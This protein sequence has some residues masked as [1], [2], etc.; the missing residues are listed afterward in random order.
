MTG[1][2]VTV[3]DGGTPI[4]VFDMEAGLPFEW[5]LETMPVEAQLADGTLMKSVAVP[6]YSFEWG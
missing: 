4:D 3:T 6:S 2:E 1:G 5:V